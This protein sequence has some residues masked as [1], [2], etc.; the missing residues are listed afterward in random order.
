MKV[1]T[2]VLCICATFA[3]SCG[4]KEKTP[5]QQGTGNDVTQ[6][7]QSTPSGVTE[8]SAVDTAKKDFVEAFGSIDGFELVSSEQGDSWRIIVQIKDKTSNGGGA[9]YTIDKATGKILERR[10]YQ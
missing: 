7:V 6:T 3:L 8:M 2:I 5:Q 4:G 1:R 10:F 9:I